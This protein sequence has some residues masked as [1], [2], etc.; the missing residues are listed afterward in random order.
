MTYMEAGVWSCLVKTEHVVGQSLYEGSLC[1]AV[2]G[3]PD[4]DHLLEH[5][6]VL[7]YLL[8][9]LIIFLDE[10]AREDDLYDLRL[11]FGELSQ[12]LEIGHRLFIRK[13]GTVVDVG[14]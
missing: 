11:S 13:S 9:L 7:E 6:W 8:P 2:E 4:L 14:E 1:F 10:L 5:A 12:T 3:L